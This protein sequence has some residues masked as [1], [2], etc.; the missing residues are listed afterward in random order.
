MDAQDGWGVARI[1]R[2]T[3]RIDKIIAI[4]P[5]FWK[6]VESTI[7][8]KIRWLQTGIRDVSWGRRNVYKVD[9]SEWYNSFSCHKASTPNLRMGKSLCILCVQSAV[10]VSFLTLQVEKTYSFFYN[11]YTR[12][13]LKTPH[14]DR[15]CDTQI[16]WESTGKGRDCRPTLRTF[17]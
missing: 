11:T 16:G 15:P 5:F 10:Y 6:L 7:K 12:N 3:V 8:N 14:A 2:S 13:W 4:P 9:H 17:R 1:T